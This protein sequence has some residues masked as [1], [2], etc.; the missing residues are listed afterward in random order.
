M[1]PI[2]TLACQ[3]VERLS[4]CRSVALHPLALSVRSVGLNDWTY[5][6]TSVVRRSL[7]QQSV[8]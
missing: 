2:G 5:F 3:F 8:V 1:R 6:G 4:V 7:H